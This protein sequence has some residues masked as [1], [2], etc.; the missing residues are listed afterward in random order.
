[1]LTTQ[2]TRAIP[3]S[4]T[5]VLYHAD[6]PDGFAS[7]WALSKRYGFD[8]VRYVPLAYGE[9]LRPGAYAG[10]SVIMVDVS[11]PRSQFLL[12]NDEVEH[13]MLIDHH[14]SASEELSD[15]PNTF[16]D[17]TRSGAG[18]AWDIAHEGSPRPLLID[19]IED[20]DLWNHVLPDTVLLRVL[21]SLPME[22][23][24]WDGFVADLENARDQMSVEAAAIERYDARS[25]E[26][27]LRHAIRMTQGGLRGWAVNAPREMAS[28]ACARL[29]ENEGCDFAMA[30]FHA[31]E[32]NEASCSWRSKA[33]STV[34]VVKLAREYGG[35]G[36]THASG[37]RMSMSQLLSLL[38]RI[39]TGERR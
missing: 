15:L 14:A 33:A 36:H 28:D 2:E 6:C 4:P 24:A 23:A 30:W 18:L 12:L 31:A 10:E 11:L 7:A 22:F 1:M 3:F 16:F 19:L 27:V 17:L 5:V 13:L 37:A 25:I 29:L 8:R 9:A 20:R 35:G 34:D 39:P 32:N 38:G 26:R 21:D